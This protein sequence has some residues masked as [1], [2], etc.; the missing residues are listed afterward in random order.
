MLFLSR[1]HNVGSSKLKTSVL[2]LIGGVCLVCLLTLCSADVT[3]ARF[4]MWQVEEYSGIEPTTSDSLEDLRSQYLLLIPEDMLM[5]VVAVSVPGSTV[6]TPTAF[7]AE[8]RDVYAGMTY[9]HRI[10]FADAQDGAIAI[11]FGIGNSRKYVG[12]DIAYTNY[13]LVG[14]TFQDG[15]VSVKLHKRLPRDLGLAIGI[16]NIVE[17]GNNDS[18]TSLYGIATKIFRFREST[19]Q[20]FSMMTLSVGAG[21]GRFRTE[22]DVLEGKKTV[23]VFGSVGIRIVRP[24][25]FIADWTGQ[26]LN[27]GLSIAPLR[28][29]PLIITGAL[30]DV[31]GSAGDGSRFVLGVGYGFSI[32]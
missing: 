18:G 26:D 28:K 10:R 8:W 32:F 27:L 23:G 29:H 25:A 9:Q 7:G 22:S 5:K 1:A 12:L 20:P 14:D 3:F 30:A 21:N 16:E 6:G 2:R 15:S 11:G 17:H 31:T 24:L 13:D 19:T 4:M